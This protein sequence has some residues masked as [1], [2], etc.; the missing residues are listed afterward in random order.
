MASEVS[1]P[2][3]LRQDAEARGFKGRS[4]ANKT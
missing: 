2:L 3:D 1:M 4:C